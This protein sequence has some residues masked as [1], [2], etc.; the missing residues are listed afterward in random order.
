MARIRARTAAPRI[1][2]PRLLLRPHRAADFEA[3]AAMWSD[4]EVTRFIGGRPSTSEETWSRLLRYAGL[5]PT[6]GFGYW[7]I[8]DRAT[9]HYVGELGFADFR[10]VIDPPLGD[11]PEAG[12]ALAPHAHGRGYAA[13]ALAAALAWADR[14]LARP[15]VSIISPENIPSL[16][17]AERVGYR[18]TARTTYKGEPTVVMRR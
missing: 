12:W 3:M 16:R 17:L 15:T 2:T 5:W 7:V 10:R 11:S 18:E 14:T 8:E 1:E 4:P 6:L 13:E 9:G